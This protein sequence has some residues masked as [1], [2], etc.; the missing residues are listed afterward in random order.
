MSVGLEFHFRRREA[1][2]ASKQLLQRADNSND[3]FYRL[4]L[5]FARVSN[6][7]KIECPVCNS[8]NT[9]ITE[10]AEKLT[11]EDCGFLF[12]ENSY[13]TPGT[14]VICGNRSFYYFS[15]FN[16]SFLGRD[17]V[18]YVCEAH[19]RKVQIGNPDR[20]FSDESFARVEQ[21]VEA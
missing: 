18:C 8:G 5:S 9:F 21:S 13:A 16:L 6:T 19:Y 20:D 3:L 17:S 11:C 1:D 4:A 2:R 12:A 7:I 15:L 14:C 10:R